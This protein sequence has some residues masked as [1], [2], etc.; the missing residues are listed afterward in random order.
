MWE[1]ARPPFSGSSMLAGE[2]R[3]IV[4]W[5]VGARGYFSS[6]WTLPLLSGERQNRIAARRF[7]GHQN[8]NIGM[9]EHHL[10]RNSGEFRVRGAR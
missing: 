4:R 10:N 2:R 8:G 6:S 1:P 7:S 3:G 5:L 9:P